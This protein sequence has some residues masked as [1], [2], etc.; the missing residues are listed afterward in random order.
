MCVFQ[1]MLLHNLFYYR[2]FKF[3]SFFLSFPAFLSK[4]IVEL[5][6]SMAPFQDCFELLVDDNVSN[7]R[8][9]TLFSPSFFKQAV[10]RLLLL[11]LQAA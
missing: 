11:L 1:H 10:P 4:G 7:I 8:V 9:A 3:L 5:I 2:L 6:F